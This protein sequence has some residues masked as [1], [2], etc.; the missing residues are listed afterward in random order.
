MQICVALL[1]AD[2]IMIEFQ[3]EK[4]IQE[5]DNRRQ[6]TW[7][8]FGMVLNPVKTILLPTGSSKAS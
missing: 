1:F 2:D 4:E 8:E 5:W 6:E 7:R 3:S